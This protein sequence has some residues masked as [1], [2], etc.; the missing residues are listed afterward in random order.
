VQT[1]IDAREHGLKITIVADACATTDPELE[2]V[3]LRYAGQVVGA[4]IAHRR[5]RAF[6]PVGLGYE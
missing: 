5:E 3:A 6:L 2:T 4:H 1:A